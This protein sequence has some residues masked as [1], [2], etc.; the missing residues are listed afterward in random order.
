MGLINL[1]LA[2]ILTQNIVLT[3]FLGVCP[4]V[5][6][7]NKEK[8]AVGMGLAVMLVVT[9]S[10]IITFFLHHFI[11]VPTGTEHLRTVMFILVIASCVQI[12]EILMK[13]FAKELYDALGIYLPLITSNCAVLG[14]VL[15]NINANYSFV[16]VLTFSIGSSLGFTL[17]IYIFSTMREKLA[18]NNI[19]EPLKGF[20]IAMIVAGI[21]ALLFSKYGA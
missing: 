2:S 19:I 15:L 17:V 7:S 8:N 9:V 1:F 14:I 3:R 5:G 4:F 6:V 16:E 11:L 10:S 18:K 13:K 12:I 21:M 20:P